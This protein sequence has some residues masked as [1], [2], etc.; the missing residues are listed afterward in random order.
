MTKKPYNA[1]VAHEGSD[2]K[3]RYTK[4]GVMFEN[5]KENGEKVYNL[6]LDFP[7]A[8]SELVMFEPKAKET[9]DE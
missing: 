9:D 5:K 3:T 4:V 2:G 7:V 6:K 8:V 1:T